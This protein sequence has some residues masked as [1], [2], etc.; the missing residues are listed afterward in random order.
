MNNVNTS[1]FSHF[2]AATSTTVDAEE[3]EHFEHLSGPSSNWQDE[4]GPFKALHSLNRIRIPWIVS[5]LVSDH[6]NNRPRMPDVWC[7]FRWGNDMIAVERAHL[8]DFA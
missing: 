8:M 3:L 7:M 6:S 5:N 4:A 1:R 2:A